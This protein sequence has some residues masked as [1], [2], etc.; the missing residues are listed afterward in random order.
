MYPY[1]G[2]V[3]AARSSGLCVC[4]GGGGG[5]GAQCVPVCAACKELRSVW[6]H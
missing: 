1:G 5:G 2:A 6:V 3:R 4:E